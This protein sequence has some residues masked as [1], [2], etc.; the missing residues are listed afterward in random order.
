MKKH[1]A[2]KIYGRVQGVFFRVEA[3]KEA[4]VLGLAGFTNNESDGTLVI[5]AE[6]E[7]NALE[8]FLSWCKK[9]PAGAYVTHV[10]M[11]YGKPKGFTEFEIKE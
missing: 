4:D 7:E 9:G 8:A 3:K 6:G 2:V 1:L 5:E 11:Q 10:E